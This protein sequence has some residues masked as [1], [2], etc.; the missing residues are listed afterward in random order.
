M[1]RSPTV[2][3]VH[4]EGESRPSGGGIRR[5]LGSHLARLEFRVALH[6]WHR[7]IPA[8]SVKPGVKLE[9]TPGIRA[10]DSF[11]MV[12]DRSPGA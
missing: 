11:P 8:Y 6:E 2:A 3:A 9:F 7:G 1:K 12:L 4:S 10:L 5:C